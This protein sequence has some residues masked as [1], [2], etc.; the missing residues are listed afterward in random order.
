MPYSLWQQSIEP[1]D[2]DRIKRH[3]QAWRRRRRRPDQ[4]AGLRDWLSRR[5]DRAP[6]PSIIHMALFLSERS[7]SDDPVRIVSIATS[8]QIV[9]I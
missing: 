6:K 2:D 9:S 1:H 5:V 7:T 4:R 8:Y 3:K